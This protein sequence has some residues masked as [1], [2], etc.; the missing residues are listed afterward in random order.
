[1]R[2]VKQTAGYA[3]SVPDATGVE[4]DTICFTTLPFYT[5]LFS[6][7]TYHPVGR[8]HLQFRVMPARVALH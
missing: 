8:P 7:G 6:P 4:P 1:M 2:V 3:P 5:F